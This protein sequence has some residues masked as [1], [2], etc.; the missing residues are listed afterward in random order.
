MQPRMVRATQGFNLFAVTVHQQ[1]FMAVRQR[2]GRGRVFG[3]HENAEPREWI[4]C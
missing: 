4:A 2:P 3:S 1:F